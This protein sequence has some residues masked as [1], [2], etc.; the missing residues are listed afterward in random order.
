MNLKKMLS[1]SARPATLAVC[2]FSVFFCL[3]AAAL[4]RSD[5]TR[6]QGPY[7]G[8]TPPGTTPQVFAPGFI[9]SPA[10]E[11]SCSFTPDGKEFYFTRKD[12]KSGRNLIMVTKCVEGTWTEPEVVPFIQNKMSFEPMVSP[13]GLRLY[14]TTERPMLGQ[15]QV[16]MTVWYV[17]RKGQGWSDPISPGYLLNPMK[18]MFVSRTLDGTIYT[19]DISGGPGTEAIV[20]A[21][22]EGGKYEKLERLG[23]PISVGSQDMYPFIAPDESYLIFASRRP[24]QN[25]NSGL[26]ISYRQTDGTWSEPRAID[27]GMPAG[28]PFVSPDGKYFFFTAGERGKSDI[29]WVEAGFIEK[30]RPAGQ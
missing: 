22:M 27:L 4:N 23:P 13:D 20:V 29:Y 18:A 6:P 5:E 8:Q 14:F 30:L 7:L 25:I 16:P 21:K 24:A 1:L 3:T 17:E 2:L 10:H 12:P 26:F 28:L 15:E 19:T 9:S 11:F